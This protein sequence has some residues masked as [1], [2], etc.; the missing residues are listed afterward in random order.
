M[1]TDLTCLIILALWGLVL[2]H[3]PAIG[4][5]KTAG[6]DWALS[7]REKLVE[8]E[9]WVGRADRAQRNHHD[10][11]AMIAVV[12]LAA[13]VAG[14][15]DSVTAIASIVLV[16]A[17]I[18]HGVTYVAGIPTARSGAYFIALLALLVIVWRI[19]T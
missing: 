6:L 4:R 17:R 5:V 16:T 19:F 15:A 2:N 14:Q 9:P 7:N 1:T 18:L 8:A 13:Q 3:G 12:I 11:L 10:N